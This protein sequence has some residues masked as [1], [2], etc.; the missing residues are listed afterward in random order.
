[1]EKRFPEATHIWIAGDLTTNYWFEDSDLDIIL[2]VPKQAIPK[3]REHLATINGREVITHYSPIPGDLDYETPITENHAIYWYLIPN[4]VPVD[5]VSSKFGR[6]YDIRNQVWHGALMPHK[7]QLTN[8]DAL[9]QRINWT[10]FKHKESTELW[11]TTWTV[12]FAAFNELSDA[13][14]LDLIDSLKRRRSRLDRMITSGLKKHPKEVWKSTEEFE[15]RLDNTEDEELAPAIIESGVLPESIAY[16]VLHKFRYS[17]LVERLEEMAE[18]DAERHLN[19]ELMEGLPIDAST[20]RVGQPVDGIA[21]QLLKR[22]NNV[23]TFILSKASSQGQTHVEDV[24]TRL[25]MFVL[26]KNRFIRSKA[27]RRRIAF[28]LYR[29]YVQGR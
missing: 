20:A 8:P 16:L 17:D 21:D 13:E 5:I 25:I 18:E 6:L 24:V 12:V 14:K 9:R 27:A 19:E 10:L 15:T 4:T 23:V 7:A 29:H 2:A 26:D 3:L 28:K 11:P 22:L 1:V